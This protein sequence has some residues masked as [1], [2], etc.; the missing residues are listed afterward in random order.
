MRMREKDIEQKIQLLYAI[1][2]RND[3]VVSTRKR[4]LQQG[5][6]VGLQKGSFSFIIGEVNRWIQ[7]ME[8][9]AFT[10]PALAVLVAFGAIWQV[11]G[12]S[13]PGDTLY[14]V[15][16][17]T[18]Q[19]PLAL[20]SHQEKP[21]L[22]IERAQ[23]RLGDLKRVA[24]RDQAGNVSSA[25][26]EFEENVPVVVA[27]VRTIVENQPER[28]VQAGREI[29]QL[30]KEKV[31]VELILGTRIDESQELDNATRQLVAYEIVDLENRSLTREQKEMLEEVHAFM[32]EERYT[33]ALE[34]IWEISNSED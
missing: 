34:Q 4:I 15:K 21:F 13:V 12:S 20:A 18:E 16:V 2:P 26:Q 11:S 32:E 31:E 17:A 25:I 30:H 23:K 7:Y 1:Q 3:W 24:Q 22:E 5:G 9:P 6:G 29:V 8:K 14:R 10:M 19:V 33:E 27:S 28:S